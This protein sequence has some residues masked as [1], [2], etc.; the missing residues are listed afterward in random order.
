MQWGP[1]YLLPVIP[2]LVWLAVAAVDRARQAAPA[3]WPS[4]RLAAGL[5]LGASVLV[6]AAGVDHVDT[7]LARNARVNQALRAAPAE[8]VV[9]GLEWLALGAGPVY[10]EKRLMLVQDSEA[11]RRLVVVLGER[12]VDRWT[13]VPWSG[14]AFDATVVERWT[15]ATPWPFHIAED[16]V[17]HGVRLI[18]YEA[19]VRRGGKLLRTVVTRRRVASWTWGG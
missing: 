17:V 14:Q 2:A 19:A 1:R 11:F 10:F 9:T 15:A 16:R 4:L 8:V 13:Y 6:Q 5:V 3:L 12:Q 18:T 7:S